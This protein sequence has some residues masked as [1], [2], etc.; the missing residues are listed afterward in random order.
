MII[1]SSYNPSHWEKEPVKVEQTPLVPKTQEIKKPINDT[2]KVIAKKPAQKK[3]QQRKKSAFEI[4][5]E[6]N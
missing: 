5:M 1:R 2:S 4:L 6:D 3:S